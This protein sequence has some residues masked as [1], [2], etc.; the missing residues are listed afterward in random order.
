ML[1]HLRPNHIS[2]KNNIF[3][4]QSREQRFYGKIA[5]D[6]IDRDAIHR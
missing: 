3:I 4:E 2:E 6:F 5:N 1:D